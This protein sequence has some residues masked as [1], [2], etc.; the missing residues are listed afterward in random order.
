MADIFNFFPLTIYK[1][2]V[3]LDETEKKILI[4]E[5]YNLEKNSQSINLKSNNK[6]WTG[7]TQGHEFLHENDK[8]KKL[9]DI[10]ELHVKKYLDKLN[11]DSKL[12][13]I[14]YSRA[15]ATISRKAENI[16]PHKHMQSNLSFAYYLNLKKTDAKLIFFD[17]SRHNEFLPGLFTSKSIN[18][19]NMITK[20]DLSNTSS[21]LFEANEDEIVIF[22]SKTLHGTQSN[23][24]N[25]DRISISADIMI[26]AKDS[27]GL[28]HLVPPIE[29]WKKFKN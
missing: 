26:H 28:E 19:K 5:I 21:I 22:P 23:I 7:D 29:K 16:S 12:L 11:I 8:F 17:E 10:I 2:K 20:R 24:N 9:F 4:N 6:S 27:S 18:K 1:S 13:S 3:G 25:E 15:W 14:Y